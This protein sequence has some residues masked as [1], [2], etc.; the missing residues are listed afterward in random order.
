MLLY[1]PTRGD[2]YEKNIYFTISSPSSLDCL[3]LYHFDT[4]HFVYNQL[5]VSN[6]MA[7]NESLVNDS[8]F[9]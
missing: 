5:G 3:G 1:K 2:L 8:F 7:Y 4:A 9:Y 6:G